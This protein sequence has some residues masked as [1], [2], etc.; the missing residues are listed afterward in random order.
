MCIL[1]MFCAF[2]RIFILFNLD[3]EA[4]FIKKALPGEVGLLTRTLYE[5]EKFT[6]LIKHMVN[7]L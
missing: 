5:N 2:H 7:V 1:T 6:L 4:L 3:D